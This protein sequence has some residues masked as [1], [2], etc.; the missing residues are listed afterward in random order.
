MKSGGDKSLLLLV[1]KV[2]SELQTS[3]QAFDALCCAVKYAI[4]KQA[5]FNKNLVQIPSSPGSHLEIIGFLE[6]F[7]AESIEGQTAAI[8]VGTILSLHF[9][10]CVEPSLSE[11]AQEILAG[12]GM[13]VTFV[14]ILP[15]LRSIIALCPALSFGD[16]LSKLQQQAIDTRVKDEYSIS[17]AKSWSLP[18]GSD[19]GTRYR[20]LRAFSI[21]A[22]LPSPL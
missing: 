7:L 22:A 11:V 18:N 5:T 1:D 3:K 13:N 4:D 16:F 9:G 17:S 20:G 2:L 6:A 8:A 12:S 10:A 15:F 19:Y 21:R 14:E